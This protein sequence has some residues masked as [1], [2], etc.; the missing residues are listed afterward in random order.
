MS[1]LEIE[2]LR[3]RA[4]AREIIRGISLSLEAGQVHIIMGQNGSGK[5]TLL[6]ALAGSPRYEVAGKASFEGKNLLSLKPHERA[7]AGILLA[8]QQP[9]EVPGV[10][11]AD[12]LRRAYCA[13]FG[14]EI[15]V[16]EF[17]SLLQRKMDELGIER[18]FAMR[19]LNEGFSGGEKKKSEMLQLSLLKPK[20]ALLDELDS[21]LDVDAAPKVAEMV[22]RARQDGASAIVVT[23]YTKILR[24]LRPDRVHV[25]KD[26]RIIL[27]GDARLAQKLEREGFGWAYRSVG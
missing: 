25:M 14:K 12:F 16:L 8:F 4:E 3:V 7:R 11:M 19:G 13:R 1:L 26:G 5:S 10:R 6:L 18:E 20:L 2:N 24:G 15:P 17:E 23:H 22:E 21:G 9:V 27:S